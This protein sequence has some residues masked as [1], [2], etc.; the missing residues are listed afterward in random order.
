MDEKN[1]IL[2]ESAEAKT[3]GPNY[4]KAE[5]ALKKF[6]EECLLQGIPM[7]GFYAVEGEET[8]EYQSEAVTPLELGIELKKDRVTV[9]SAALTGTVIEVRPVGSH[10]MTQETMEAWADLLVEEE[11]G[12]PEEYDD[13]DEN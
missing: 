2:P 1:M 12:W 9:L 5:A 11:G 10:D 6:R 8:T 4:E 7:L 13:E 3:G